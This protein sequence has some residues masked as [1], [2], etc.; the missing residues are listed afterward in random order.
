MQ[1]MHVHL[2]TTVALPLSLVPSALQEDSA[3]LIASKLASMPDRLHVGLVSE[4]FH[5]QAFDLLQPAAGAGSFEQVLGNARD[6]FGH[7]VRG[8]DVPVAQAAPGIDL[9]WLCVCFRAG[10]HAWHS[11]GEHA[12][13]PGRRSGC[14]TGTDSGSSAGSSSGSS[15]GGGGLGTVRECLAQL[16]AMP[17][18]E[19]Q[20]S[21]SVRQMRGVV[22][23]FRRS[24]LSARQLAAALLAYWEQCAPAG[25]QLELAQALPPAVVPT[26]AVPTWAWRAARQQGRRG[27]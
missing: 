15:S 12:A 16:Q 27:A 5:E 11:G 6:W 22:H 19:G 2:S 23:S 4:G 25:E 13:N 14:R 21:M 20:P 10:W 9:G 8:L 3:A 18:L 24:L 7:T 26:C 1:L 17:R